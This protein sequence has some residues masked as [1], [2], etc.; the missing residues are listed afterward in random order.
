MSEVS[1]RSL[2]IEYQ[3][4]AGWLPAVAGAS[5]DLRAGGITGLVGEYG[6]GKTTLALALLNAVPESGRVAAGSIEVAGVGD[7]LSLSG[8]QLRKVR[9]R[10]LGYVFQASQNSMNPLKTIGKQLLDLGRSHE[11][12]DL[13][14]LIARAK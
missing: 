14:A 10:S 4:S 12:K 1:V 3:T 13:R 6:S 7:V 8:N 9:G 11:V 5:L 2:T